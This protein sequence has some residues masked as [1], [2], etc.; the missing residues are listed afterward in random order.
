M[1]SLGNI[2]RK[3]VKEMLTPATILPILF[4]TLLFGSM[5]SMIG[6][7]EEEINEEPVIGLIDL[8]NSTLSRIAVDVIQTNAKVIYNGSEIADTREGLDTVKERE[9]IALFIIHENFTSGIYENKSGEIEVLWIMKGAGL[10]DDISTQVAGHILAVVDYHISRHLIGTNSSVNS[11]TVLSPTYRNDTTYFKGKEMKGLSPTIITAMLSQQSLMIPILIMM[12]IM[13][14]GGTVISSM[15]MEKENKTLET[16]LT[17]PV[18]RTYIVTGKLVGSAIVGLIMAAI[19]MVGFGY[20]MS[21]LSMSNL[22]M[23]DYGFTLGGVDYLLIALSLFTALLAGLA[24]CMVLGTFAKNYKSA[25]TLTFPVTAL[26]MIPMF[27]VM[28]KDFETLPFWLKGILFAIPFSHPMMAMRSLLFGEYWLVIAGI[29]YVS[30]FSMAMIAIAVWIFKSD[31][32]LTG[33]MSKRWK[34][35]GGMM[36]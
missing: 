25:Q 5:G 33:S 22:N 12:L 18:K 35:F 23:E 13:M 28:F 34:K 26:A 9:G 14:S 21:N 27:L 4:M 31:R 36:Q 24:L 2:I 10:M 16:L 3:E 11:T 1:S 29:I 15:G 17:L 8:D 20:Y 32:L 6:S 7:I 30:M 19:Y